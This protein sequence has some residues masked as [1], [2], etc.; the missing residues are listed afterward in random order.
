MTSCAQLTNKLYI[1][2]YAKRHGYDLIIDYEEHAER[3]T[4]WYKFDMIER[5]IRAGTHDWIW[6]LDFDT[7][8][9]NTTTPVTDVIDDALANITNPKDVD[10]IL[11]NDW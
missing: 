9:T 3:G 6:W 10:F 4:M 2:D 7:L 1:P 8:I 11:T 5:I